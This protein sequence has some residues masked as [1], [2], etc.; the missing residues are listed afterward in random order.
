MKNVKP[1]TPLFQ[2]MNEFDD[3]QSKNMMG[4][5]KSLIRQRKW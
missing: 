5:K 4:I 2:S 3:I 1:K